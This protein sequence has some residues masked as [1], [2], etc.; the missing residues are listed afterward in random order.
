MAIAGIVLVLLGFALVAPRGGTTGS[1]AAR[2]I[3]MH[4]Q[5]IFRTPGYQQEP[6]RNLRVWTFCIGLVMLAVGVVLIALGT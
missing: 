4:G 2:N 1:I 3:G 5:G 6:A